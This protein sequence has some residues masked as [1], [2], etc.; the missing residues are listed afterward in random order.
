MQ[1][2]WKFDYEM[3]GQHD[4]GEA[5]A[6]IA[7]KLH[8]SQ[9][10]KQKSSWKHS[11]KRAARVA[12]SQAESSWIKPCAGSKETAFYSLSA[13]FRKTKHRALETELNYRLTSVSS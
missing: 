2:L 6:G 4:W 11:S 10:D 5:S 1:V 12:A 8:E 3:D 7:G 9:G 13:M